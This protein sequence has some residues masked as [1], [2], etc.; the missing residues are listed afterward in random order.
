MPHA[1]KKERD[2]NRR[3]VSCQLNPTQRQHVVG[4]RE[5]PVGLVPG[6][7]QHAAGSCQREAGLAETSG[8]NDDATAASLSRAAVAAE[9]ILV[10]NFVVKVVPHVGDLRPMSVIAVIAPTTSTPQTRPHSRVSVPASSLR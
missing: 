8:S 5:K 10:G 6:S 7:R 2:A 9:L 4:C 1:R 3:P